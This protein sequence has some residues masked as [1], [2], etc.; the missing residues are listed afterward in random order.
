MP[1]S[2]FAPAALKKASF[3][4]LPLSIRNRIYTEVVLEKLKTPFEEHTLPKVCEQ[5]HE[6]FVTIYDYYVL[7][8]FRCCLGRTMQDRDTT[9]F[10]TWNYH[11]TTWPNTEE[12][13]PGIAKN[14]R[15]CEVRCTIEELGEWDRRSELGNNI[16][17]ECLRM[18]VRTF[19]DCQHVRM[20]VTFDHF[21]LSGK[22]G[23]LNADE[24]FTRLKD[25]TEIPGLEE[26]DFLMP[27]FREEDFIW[28]KEQRGKK[29]RG[30]ANWYRV[31]VEKPTQSTHCGANVPKGYGLRRGIT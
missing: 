24:T 8:R 21:A 1:V 11:G 27:G 2:L 20:K 16:F 17:K 3:L 23:L 9:K 13:P 14:L 12:I 5:I 29:G 26:I 6:E 10:Y 19:K 30:K 4:G 7:S 25:L 31:E 18:L 15:R 28:R 22:R